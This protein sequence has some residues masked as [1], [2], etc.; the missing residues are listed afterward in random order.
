MWILG[1]SVIALRSI[2][3]F[4]F[5]AHVATAGRERNDG[6]FGPKQLLYSKRVENGLFCRMI[7]LPKG[8][9]LY[10]KWGQMTL[11]SVFNFGIVSFRC[12]SRRDIML[13]EK[14]GTSFDP[15]SR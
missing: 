2:P 6:S 13:V 14:R 9:P 4:V 7:F 1:G 12:L 10:S 3:A 8:V 15:A 11:F 5:P